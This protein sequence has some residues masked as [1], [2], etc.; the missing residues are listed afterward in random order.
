M[1]RPWKARQP[2]MP[3]QICHE[4]VENQEM[5]L[6]ARRSNR[7]GPSLWPSGLCAP[8]G[9]VVARHQ[10]PRRLSGL[11]GERGASIVEF[12]LVLP[13]FI[14]LLM[15]FVDFGLNLN[16]ISSVRQAVREG[17]RDVAVGD[18]GDAVCTLSAPVT[19]APMPKTKTLLCGIKK[20]VPGS[21]IRV[22]LVYPGGHTAGQKGLV[23]AQ[24]Q[25]TSATGFYRSLLSKS[26]T[27]VRTQMRI[28]RIETGLDEFS[29]DSFDG[30]NWTWC[31]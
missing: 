5:P 14:G 23:C 13:L 7:K 10:K 4:V 20:A 21:S 27:K 2:E 8:A 3:L 17:A 29:E 19:P 1:V 24:Y 12:A 22:R 9:W 15:G 30:Q 6:S 28:E 26:V 31:L 16:N 11:A 25:V 18:P